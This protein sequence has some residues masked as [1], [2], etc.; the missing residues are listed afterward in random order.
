MQQPADDTVLPTFVGKLHHNLLSVQFLS[1]NKILFRC[2]CSL[3]SNII[4]KQSDVSI[5]RTSFQ[6]L[7]LKGNNAGK[8]EG[9]RK[10]Y[11]HNSFESVLMLLAKIIK[12]SSC[13]PK[14]QFAKFAAF[15]RHSIPQCDC[16]SVTSSC[17]VKYF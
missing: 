11:C 8:S 12:I 15:L 3:L 7:L 14:L 10:L 13:L 17:V 5:C 6:S 4:Y 16:I 9:I 1:S 2:L